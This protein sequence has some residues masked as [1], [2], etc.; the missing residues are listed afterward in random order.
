MALNEIY[1]NGESL[2]HLVESGVK[3]GDIVFVGGFPNADGP[4][5]VSSGLRGVAETDAKLGSD[6]N[7]YA[8]VRHVGVFEF[9]VDAG[10]SVGQPVYLD[11]PAGITYGSTLTVEAP[12]AGST[13]YCAGVLVSGVFSTPTGDLKAHVR[14]NN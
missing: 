10:A 13:A 5:E 1:A 12:G 11:A 7:Y 8:T 4:T 6:G 2:S 3:S 9:E 14:I